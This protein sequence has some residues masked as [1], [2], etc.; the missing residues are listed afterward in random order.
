M[1][2]DKAESFG[3]GDTLGPSGCLENECVVVRNNK[4]T[5]NLRKIRN[6]QFLRMFALLILCSNNRRGINIFR[7]A[8]HARMCGKLVS[9][10][11]GK[12]IHDDNW[13]HDR[14]QYECFYVPS[15]KYLK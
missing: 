4:S 15:K 8:T 6:K 3:K 9:E 5:L 11:H 7:T 1:A 12:I 2:K 13:V 10:Q 14:L